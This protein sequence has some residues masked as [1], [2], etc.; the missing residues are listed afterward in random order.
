MFIIIVLLMIF[1]CD[2]T[3]DQK[4][5]ESLKVGMTADQVI[6]LVGEPAE[7]TILGWAKNG[8]DTLEVWHYYFQDEIMQEIQFTDRNVSRVIL[9]YKAEQKMIKDLMDNRKPNND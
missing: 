4:K 1:S 2:K 7:K 6:N 3:N 5:F 8:G 9:D